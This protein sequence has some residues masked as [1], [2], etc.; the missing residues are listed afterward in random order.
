LLLQIRTL[1]EVVAL[2]LQV[3]HFGLVDQVDLVAFVGKVVVAIDAGARVMVQIRVVLHLGV[4]HGLLVGEGVALA[5]VVVAHV[6]DAGCESERDR[7]D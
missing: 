6:Q 7:E 1:Q 3:V 2:L 5:K 4:G